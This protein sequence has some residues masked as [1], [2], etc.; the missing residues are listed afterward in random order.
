VSETTDRLYTIRKD[1]LPT[2]WGVAAISDL[3]GKVGVFVDGD[4]VE[5]KDQDP[6][7]D[8][9]LIQLADIGDGEYKNKSARFLSYKKA[10]ELGC[11]FL[12][13]GDVL[14]ARMPDPLGRACIFPGD[15]KKAVTAVDVAIVRPANDE[16]NNR[17]LMHFVNAPA[18]RAAVSSMQSGS[19]RKRISRRNLARIVLPVPPRKK[20]DQIV[21][22]V[23]KQF[24]RLDEAVTSLKRA[25]VSL[26]HYKAAVLKAAVEGKLTEQWRKENPDVEPAEKLLG[27]IV[28]ECGNPTKNSRSTN[29]GINNL[30]K[31]PKT[32]TWTQLQNVFDVITDG[33]HQP[34]PQTEK[35]VPFLVIGNVRTGKLDFSNTRFVSREYFEGID[36]NRVP[37]M[38]DILF[39]VVGSYGIPVLIDTD[40][41]FCVQRHIAILKPSKLVNSKY[42]YYALKSNI[43]FRQATKVA[44]G[45]AQKTVP[46]S[47]L[48]TIVIPI[49]PLIEQGKIV[50]QLEWWLPTTEKSEEMIQLNFNRTDRLRQSILKKAFSGRLV[51]QTKG[52]PPS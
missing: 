5:S 4:W 30:L 37:G 32:W 27:R 46:L 25:K 18:F 26:K 1:E 43:V 10:L 2:G 51:P 9:R 31:L 42:L 22:E 50:E 24:S 16:F 35:G 44:T 19:T 13:K 39:T 34:P 17:W 29:I 48:R 7:G 40:Q 11:T 20:Q 12:D 3:V 23:E 47:G 15:Q 45:T 33:D 52:Q 38:G 8:V 36:A 49:P 21:D 6:N 14:I 41:N 28:T